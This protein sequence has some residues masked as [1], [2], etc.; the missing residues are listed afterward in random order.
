MSFSSFFRR[1]RDGLAA[2]TPIS[3]PTVPPNSIGP[4]A[5]PASSN[6]T[7]SS[8]TTPPIAST[9]SGLVA[10]STNGNPMKL[11]DIEALFATAEKLLAPLV[12]VADA[13]AKAS[14]NQKLEFVTGAILKAHAAILEIE[15]DFLAAKP[16]LSKLV[17][18]FADLRHSS[19][20]A[21][22]AVV[23]A[24]AAAAPVAQAAS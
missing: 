17:S 18:D 5:L 8:A 10:S 7:P 14:G 13:A 11:A 6:A 2:P 22:V 15:A 3:V 21:P 12:S 4:S 16:L 23:P 20:T 1:I 9:P 24:A 19:K